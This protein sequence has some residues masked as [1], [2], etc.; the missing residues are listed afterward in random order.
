MEF[1]NTQWII[2]RFEAMG[3]TL[4]YGDHVDERDVL[5]SS[6]IESRVAD[7]H[8]AFA[9]PNVDGIIS[10]IG[11][12]TSNE[13]LPYLDW[14]LI[15]ANPKVFCGYSDFTTLANA[16]HA[17][18]GLLTY[19]GAHWSSFGMRDH[20]E[21]T[22]QW[23]RKATHEFEWSIEH[24]SEFTDDLWFMNQDDRNPLRTDG[25]WILNEGDAGGKV[26][27]G[28]LCT[29]NLLQ[30]GDCMPSLD[31][32]VLFLE[33]DGAV[34]AH[35]FARDL[36]SL[37][38]LPEA[39]NILGLAIGRFQTGSQVTREQLELIISKHPLLKEVPVVANL[40]FGHTSPMFTLPIGG[41]AELTAH[42][43]TVSLN[44]SHESK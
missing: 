30:G 14:D 18:T 32:T 19:V 10:V 15:A 8:A 9:D 2:E 16:V 11:G 43:S 24:Q 31:G 42:G 21:P 26:I 7:L 23:F 20:F 25:P 33:D 6:S 27:G 28:N 44:F 29:L 3:L 5:D 37:L 17:R 35:D 12:F 1:D 36:A 22:G 4:Q 13:L 41:F 40:D 39:E 34:G 38:Q